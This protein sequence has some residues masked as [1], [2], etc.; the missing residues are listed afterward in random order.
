MD[1]SHQAQA[2]VFKALCDPKRL[3]VL[4][5]LRSGEKCACVLLDALELTQ[6]GLSYHMKILCESGIVASRPEGKWTYYRLD[7][8][9]S[10]YAV[11]LLR[12]LTTPQAPSEA[13]C[14]LCGK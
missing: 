13:G 2:K 11:R 6:S 12:E 10:D 1:T 8:S 3:S 4:E 9:G 14:A 5:Q 7:P